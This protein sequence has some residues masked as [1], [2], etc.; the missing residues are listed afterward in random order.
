MLALSHMGRVN[1]GLLGEVTHRHAKSV[2][3]TFC[4]DSAAQQHLIGLDFK[5]DS[6]NLEN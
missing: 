5:R 6:E 4:A 1:L 3:V 2:I